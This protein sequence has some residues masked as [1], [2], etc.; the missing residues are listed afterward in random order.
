VERIAVMVVNRLHDQLPTATAME[1]L[2]LLAAEKMFLT[3]ADQVFVPRN[4]AQRDHG[5]V[6]LG[7]GKKRR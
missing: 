2:A 6:S 4:R 3:T 7:Q 5:W 1:A